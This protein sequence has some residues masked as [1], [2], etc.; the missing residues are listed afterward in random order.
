MAWLAIAPAIFPLL[1]GALLIV[2]RGNVALQRWPALLVLVVQVALNL[3]LLS[4]VYHHG[5]LSLTMGNWLPPFGISFT[6]D[7]LGAVLAFTSALV[8]LAC[9]VYAFGE[10][11]QPSTRFGFFPM[12]LVLV[13]GM[14]GAFLTGDIFNL[15]VWLEI[16]LIS[17]FGL[18]ILGGRAVQLDGGVK[19]AFLNL[20]ATTI[21][22]IATGLLYGAMGTLNFA[23]L[24]GKAAAYPSRG[25]IAVIAT[26]YL[27]AL[28][29]KAAAFPLFFWLPASY[30]TPKFV[31]SALFAGLLTK[32]GVYGIYRVFTAVFAGDEAFAAKIVTGVAGL[33]ILLGAAGAVAQSRLRPMLDYLVIGGIG[34]ML[35]GF[36]LGTEA[37]RAAGMFYMVQSMLVMAGL[38]LLSG[39]AAGRARGGDAFAPVHWAEAPAL[40]AILFLCFGFAV[41]GLP[42]FSGFWPKFMLVRESLAQGLGWGVATVLIGGFLTTIAIARAFSAMFWQ[43]QV[44]RPEEEL[45]PSPP[46]RFAT[47]FPV[48]LLAS[49]AVLLGLLP[50]R[51]YLFAE[52]AA[53]GLSDYAPYIKAVFGVAP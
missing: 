11:D 46:P 50:D 25:L 43:P 12:L 1:A 16:L 48:L 5:V 27:V 26:L 39:L 38:Y 10:I 6:V 30:H 9:G 35:L 7:M 49:S 17:S 52:A 40:L 41:A 37:A 44:Q 45:Q 33:T 42:P 13:A 34:Y 15:Y 3:G 2:F 21:F 23:D 18:I 31:V 19:Y 14:N 29:T 22:L 24:V 47:I 36:G 32:V 53:H 51:L 28:G 4:E 20:V 8:A